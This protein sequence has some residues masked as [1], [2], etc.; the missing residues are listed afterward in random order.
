MCTIKNTFALSFL[1]TLWHM[2]SLNKVVA[3]AAPEPRGLDGR[4]HSAAT[5]GCFSATESVILQSNTERLVRIIW[6]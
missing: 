4:V 1:L 6:I 3:E 2:C 5:G